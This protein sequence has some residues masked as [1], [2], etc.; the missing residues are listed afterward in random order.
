MFELV[1]ELNVMGRRVDLP[2]L[3]FVDQSD[4]DLAIDSD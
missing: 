4:Q 3:R 1:H 2:N